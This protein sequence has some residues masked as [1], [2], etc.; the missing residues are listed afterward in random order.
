VNNFV[1]NAGLDIA[2][3]CRNAAFNKMPKP[4]AKPKPRK[5]NDLHA[6]A[7]PGKKTRRNYEKEIF[8]YNRAYPK[9]TKLLC[10]Q[11]KSEL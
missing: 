1:E 5:I 8:V 3:A 9:S 4:E 11:S 6:F 10:L 7:H 2:K